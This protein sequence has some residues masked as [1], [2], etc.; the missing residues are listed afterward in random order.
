M[1]TNF[2][3]AK[4]KVIDPFTQEERIGRKHIGKRSAAGWYCWDCGVTLF[5]RGAEFVHHGVRNVTE[6][7]RIRA[8]FPKHEIDDRGW[9]LAC[10]KCGK[11]RP[12]G[13]DV[14]TR[15]AAARELGFDKTPFAPRTGVDTCSSFS[16]AIDPESDEYKQLLKRWGKPIIDEYDTKY[17]VKEWLKMLEECPLRYTHS[18]GQVFS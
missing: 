9:L 18:I 1:G 16:W 3:I 10:P 8:Q 11:A 2:Y 6:A 5:A 12:D 14:L 7:D 13:K 4:T 17:S 15:G